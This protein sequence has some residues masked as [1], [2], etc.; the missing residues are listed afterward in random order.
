MST[1]LDTLARWAAELLRLPE[2]VFAARDR[3]W[4][5]APLLLALLLPLFLRRSRSAVPALL[6]RALALLALVAL[7]LE[8]QV[9]ERDR[10]E[11]SLL[12]IADVSPSVGD[13][14]RAREKEYLAGAASPF[15]LV[16]FGATPLPEFEPDPRPATDIGRA[17]TM[18]N[19]NCCAS[20]CPPASTA[21]SASSDSVSTY[22]RL[23][24]NARVANSITGVALA[25]P[26][27]CQSASGA[28]FHRSG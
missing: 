7:L 25:A 12:V 24:R 8:P 19:A 23:S 27:K 13:M 14:G 21:P 9:L 26:I 1:A 2:V 20:R 17:I 6:L 11:G 16:A 5:A 18:S 15:D 4:L 10:V 3:I 22:A 28:T